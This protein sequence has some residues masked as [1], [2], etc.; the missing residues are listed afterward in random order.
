[1]LLTIVVGSASHHVAHAW[2]PFAVPALTARA[3]GVALASTPS[4]ARGGSPR[5]AVVVCSL[6]G[7]MALGE[8]ERVLGSFDR[9]QQRV[10]KEGF[11]GQREGFGGGTS[12]AKWAAAYPDWPA[13]RDAVLTIADE[14]EQVM[15]ITEYELVCGHSCPLCL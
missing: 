15:T 9:E 14:S 5:W 13:L 2:Q 4:R 1:M 11:N 8:A 6:G 12:A 10:A 3:A 7:H